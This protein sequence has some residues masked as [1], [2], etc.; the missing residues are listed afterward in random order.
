[1]IL[2][3]VSSGGWVWAF[4]IRRTVK[5]SFPIMSARACWER[6]ARFRASTSGCVMA[7]LVTPGVTSPQVLFF[8]ARHTPCST[9]NIRVG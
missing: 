8:G 6:F 9:C 5:R 4:S 7:D 1:M 2:E 3:T